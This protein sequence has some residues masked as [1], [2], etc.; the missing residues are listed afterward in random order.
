MHSPWKGW[1]CNH[2]E[3]MKLFILGCLCRIPSKFCSSRA[4][5]PWKR[6][7][8][9]WVLAQPSVQWLCRN[10]HKCVSVSQCWCWIQGVHG[11][12]AW[13]LQDSISCRNCRINYV[14]PRV[15]SDLVPREPLRAFGRHLCLSVGWGKAWE[16]KA[17]PLNKI[18]SRS[19][20]NTC[21]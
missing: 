13:P 9:M 11:S 4:A 15:P 21:A 2:K 3:S 5:Q 18:R 16:G 8:K 12:T 10:M 17:L 7:H 14:K 1:H 20:I 19:T 6:S